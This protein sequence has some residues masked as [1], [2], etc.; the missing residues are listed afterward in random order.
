MLREKLLPCVTLMWHET[1]RP[2]DGTNRNKTD[3]RRS[4]STGPARPLQRR[5]GSPFL[6]EAPQCGGR[7]QMK[8][9]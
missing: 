5:V 3:L 2:V 9:G 8:G 4:P 6:Q 1:T 7:Q